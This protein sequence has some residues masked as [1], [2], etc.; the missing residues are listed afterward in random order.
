MRYVKGL[1]I[2][3]RQYIVKVCYCIFYMIEI[4]ICSFLFL[5][6]YVMENLVTYI[7]MMSLPYNQDK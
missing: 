3:L 4:C 6:N 5:L 2:F 1:Y 7:V